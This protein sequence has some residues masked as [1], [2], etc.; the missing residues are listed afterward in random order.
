M[1]LVPMCECS[2]AAGTSDHKLCSRS[3]R[4]GP[5]LPL[6]ASGGSRNPL[7]C[8]YIPPISASIFMWLLL[9]ASTVLS[10][11]RTLSL[12]MTSVVIVAATD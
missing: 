7:T 2:G 1:S 12:D 3:S 10:L 9:S 11:L 4:G 6:P 8:G 5:L